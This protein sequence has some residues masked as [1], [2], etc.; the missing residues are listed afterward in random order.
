[1]TG[2]WKPKPKKVVET[3]LGKAPKDAEKGPDLSHLRKPIATSVYGLKQ[4]VALFQTATPEVQEYITFE[5]DVLYECRFCKTI[6]R[7]LANFILH[8]R[9]Y[10]RNKWHGGDHNEGGFVIND[11][12]K[13]SDEESR[14][15]TPVEKID[16]DKT[17]SND[18]GKNNK[19]AI[20][21][22]I[23]KLLKKQ[24]VK[25]LA[26]DTLNEDLT[27]KAENSDDDVIFVSEE[28][29]LVLQKIE[30]SRAAVF[31]TS[32]KDC[33]K[34]E[35]SKEGL[36]KGEI[37]E[38]HGILDNNQAA[39][40]SNGK[41][42][43]FETN[44]LSDPNI[45]KPDL[46]CTECNFTFS[47]EKTLTHHIKYKHNK[48]CTVYPCPD[49]KETFSNAWSVYRHLYKVHRRT[50]S[51]VRRMRYLVHTSRIRKD[52]EPEKK[53]RKLNV[54]DENE[55]NQ[56]M[57]NFEGDKDF[58]MCGGCG[59]R[60][61]R[62]AALHSHSQMCVKRIAVCNS[63]KN[64]KSAKE[65]KEKVEESE[66]KLKGAARRKQSVPVIMP[67]APKED[68]PDKDETAKEEREEPKKDEVKEVAITQSLD[69]DVTITRHSENDTGSILNELPQLP[70]IE[71]FTISDDS[72][73][74][75][76][77]KHKRKMLQYDRN[78]EVWDEFKEYV[79]DEEDLSFLAQIMTYVDRTDL[80]CSPCGITFMS[81]YMLLRHMSLHFS[82]F[83][84]Q[85]S[86]C[87]F[88]SFHKYDCTTHAYSRHSTPSNLIE[89]TVLPI[90][91]WKVLCTSHDFKHFSENEDV[92]DV[93]ISKMPLLEPV[94]EKVETN[95]V[96]TSETIV[97]EDDEMPDI[98]E[99]GS[100]SD[101]VLLSDDERKETNE[102]KKEAKAGPSLVNSRPIRNRTR[103][104]KTVQNDFIYDLANV[105]KFDSSTKNKKAKKNLSK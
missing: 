69:A 94:K 77:D 98:T 43:T 39:L 92:E 88:M 53:K 38:I 63:I 105:L 89:S 45:P 59:K 61:E 19:K 20:L 57:N 15:T 35:G 52:Q 1:M 90:P 64:V 34:L 37:M 101:T 49:C 42:C 100:C 62:K 26:K 32:V 67:T 36:M 54:E 95:G 29:N 84:F 8:K 21:P 23:D 66:V 85:C 5:C 70:E 74:F 46:V 55:E 104:V 11:D 41:V 3:S 87:S 4:L 28:N 68:K 47:T 102:K 13:T 60:F 96:E 93:T 40:G 65:K 99:N 83:R 76:L 10:C 48:T 24:K 31:Q 80:K 22:I 78:V 17:D 2:K 86:K 30:S 7:S 27:A 103:S 91:K 73:D 56:W 58:Q 81:L 33:E 79:N 97:L 18:G 44:K 72:N 50:T 71:I 16:N 75:D 51:Q 82:W 14:S 12:F 25:L 6:F 9:N